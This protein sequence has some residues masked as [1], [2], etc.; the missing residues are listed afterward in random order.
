M[1]F[2]QLIEYNPKIASFLKN[3]NWAYLWNNSLKFYV[4][5]K[6]RGWGVSKYIE[7]KLHTTLFYFIQSFPKNQKEIWN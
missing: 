2:G 6:I 1:K 3:Q 7:T 4:Y 5:G